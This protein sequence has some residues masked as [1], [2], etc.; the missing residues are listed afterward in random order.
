M[1]KTIIHIKGE[2]IRKATKFR[3]TDY[4]LPKCGFH[5]TEK[6]RPR[7]KVNRHNIDKFL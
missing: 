2:D 4:K 7:K 5:M 1:K 6:D 3:S